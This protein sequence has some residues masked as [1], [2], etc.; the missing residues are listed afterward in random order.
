MKQFS[1]RVFAAILVFFPG[2]TAATE[3]HGSVTPVQKVI[4][5]LSGMLEK[6]KKEKHDEQ[7][8]FATYKQFCEDTDMHVTKQI[9][10]ADEK[11]E[12]LKADIQKY[13]IESENL[14]REVEE[15]EGNVAVMVGDQKA[16]AK[17]R[18]LERTEYEKTHKDYTESID[19]IGKA[20]VILK[21]Q[22][23]DRKQA[24]R[25][26]ADANL[27][28]A[29]RKQ[30]DAL[31]QSIVSME[32]VPEASKRA[33]DVFLARGSED[34]ELVIAS[35]QEPE[36]Y[37]YEFQS[38]GVIDLLEKLKDKFIEERSALEK[39]ELSARHASAM[40]QQDLKASISN[41]Q[42]AIS[43]KSQVKSKDV[44]FVA[45]REGDLEDT[46]STQA[47]DAK[48]LHGLKSSCTQKSKD[49]EVRQKLRAEE[50]S[51]I[52]K[53]IGVLSSDNVQA[54]ASKHLPG[55][56]QNS[57]QGL[58]LLL[59]LRSDKNPTNQLRVAAYLNE[60]ATRIGSSVLSM[61]ATRAS[62]DP[63][64]KVKK[65]IQD[66]ISRLMEQAGEEAQHKGWCDTEL[67]ENEKV[68]TSRT[69]SVDNLRSEIEEL[70][71]S[72]SKIGA[73]I[74][75]LTTQVAGLDG[76]AAEETEIR[77][78][79][80]AKNEA[81]I[82]DAEDAQAAVRSA[83]LVLK[84][85]YATASE[86]TAFA[87]KSKQNPDA[88]AVFDDTPYTGIG[89]SG[90]VIGMLEVIESDFARL[91]S[92]T[93]ASEVAQ[94]NAHNGFMTES[95]MTK[96]QKQS[97]ITH[98]TSQKQREE[99]QLSDKQSDLIAEEK[100]LNAA[101]VY[102]DKLKP[103]CLDAGMSFQEREARR[104]EEIQSLQEALRILNG[105]DIALLQR[106]Q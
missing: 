91:E 35:S 88:P 101:N 17:V 67:A 76:S 95:A 29:A 31:L 4:Q 85:F 50:L 53:A 81:T 47:D 98:K 94:A 9:K 26:Q 5:M 43:T 19:A 16:A 44:Q 75:E 99:Q 97:D 20:V 68:R 11:I 54:A 8:Q 3:M 39:A 37:G 80:K 79:E 34:A 51:V 105:E 69:A 102:F 103:S 93:R 38:H 33:I 27:E 74:T 104:Q 90:G 106:Q 13:Q 65:M 72:I 21:K 96:A 12:V 56:L 45:S 78:K 83:I 41:A 40:L 22:A 89:G 1:F 48:Y 86:P 63:F 10:E 64:S 32:K 42:T 49:F 28:E 73:E 14:A 25:K 92:D 58:P 70:S 66:L 46:M 2:S 24:D 87:Q 57:K 61:I 18:E 60:Q 62:D 71:A 7:I 23:Y 30:A 82:K 6:G 52:E 59:Q 77:Q 15:L 55:M 36:A 100:E 84:E